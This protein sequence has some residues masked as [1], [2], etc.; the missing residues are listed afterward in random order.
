MFSSTDKSNCRN[1]RKIPTV[2]ESR[3]K[4]CFLKSEVI[5]SMGELN[6]DQAPQDINK[7]EFQ[8]E[9]VRLQAFLAATD[10][11]CKKNSLDELICLES[12]YDA[13]EF[14][15]FSSS[16]SHVLKFTFDKDICLIFKIHDQ[17]P[18]AVPH[19]SVT[20]RKLS[21]AQKN[22]I[23]DDLKIF[24]EGLIGT[25]MIMDLVTKFREIY[26]SY[27]EQC[28]LSEQSLSQSEGII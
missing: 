6:L 26:E 24:A 19:I 23:E 13:S 1:S 5:L 27:Q 15:H 22:K 11:G 8:L 21:N 4:L 2:V 3:T 25:Y 7:E 18:Q 10:P 12:S 16:Q 20:S 28:V 9:R 17:Y 14:F